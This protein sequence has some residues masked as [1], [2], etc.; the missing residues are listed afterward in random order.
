[1]VT[2]Q[3]KN[4]SDQT[5]RGPFTGRVL[6]LSSEIGEPHVVNAENG[7]ALLGGIWRFD[8][9]AQDGLLR[10]GELSQSKTLVFELSR[11]APYW[12]A[13]KGVH[14]NLVSFDLQVLGRKME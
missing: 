2:V 5:F 1:L 4:L 13:G 11:P 12:E 3:V 7:E 14:R 10:P 6:A 9:P 8:A